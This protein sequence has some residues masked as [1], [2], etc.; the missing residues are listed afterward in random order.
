MSQKKRWGETFLIFINI[1]CFFLQNGE[2]T[3]SKNHFYFLGRIFFRQIDY[4]ASWGDTETSIHH[5]MD[6]DIAKSCFWGHPEMITSWVKSG[7]FTAR[8]L[9]SWRWSEIFLLSC[10]KMTWL[11]ADVSTSHVEYSKLDLRFL[12][13]QWKSIK[14]AKYFFG[15]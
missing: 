11:E 6:D 1:Q 7:T 3:K 13:R 4:C 9:L 15:N 8:H 2:M 12:A 10:P 5:R 14:P